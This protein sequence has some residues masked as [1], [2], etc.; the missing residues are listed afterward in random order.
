MKDGPFVNLYR[1]D[2]GE[3]FNEYLVVKGAK[4]GYSLH[5]I[6]VGGEH[7]L[8]VTKYSSD[9]SLILR[10]DGKTFRTHQT[11]HTLW[12]GSSPFNLLLI[13]KP[14]VG[15]CADV[16]TLS[17]LKP[18]V[19]C[20]QL[21]QERFINFISLDHI[22]EVAI[23]FALLSSTISHTRFLFIKSLPSIFQCF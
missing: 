8:A 3:T 15:V 23:L 9:P 5:H 11:I 22:R 13:M 16:I 7:L 4:N 12:V 19:I 10:W 1:S 14:G 6:A 18:F 20:V 21:H 2:G 17:H